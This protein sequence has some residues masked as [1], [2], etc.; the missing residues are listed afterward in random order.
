MFSRLL[1]VLL[2]FFLLAVVVL[3]VL[4]YTVYDYPFGIFKLFLLK[5]FELIFHVALIHRRNQRHTQKSFMFRLERI[6]RYAEIN[7]TCL[8]FIYFVLP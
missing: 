3:S 8:H 5:I 2:S 4:R 7:S 1:F 6:Q